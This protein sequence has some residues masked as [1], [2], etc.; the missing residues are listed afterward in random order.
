MQKILGKVKRALAVLLVAAMTVTAAPQAGLS[1]YA[2]EP[3][4]AA[5]EGSGTAKDTGKDPE[6]TRG[7]EGSENGAD[8]GESGSGGTEADV[9]EEPDGSATDGE[10]NPD[11]DVTEGKDNVL[12]EGP[13][14]GDG[15]EQ[16]APDSGEGTDGAGEPEDT[17]SGDESVSG[18]TAEEDGT[19]EAGSED[20]AVAINLEDGGESALVTVRVALPYYFDNDAKHTQISLINELW[21]AVG[22]DGELQ[23]LT[24][25]EGAFEADIP[26]E[27][28]KKLRLK[29]VL[30][31]QARLRNVW[32]AY[33]G[34][35]AESGE[36][37]AEGGEYALQI[38][39]PSNSEFEYD[40]LVRINAEH[41]YAITFTDMYAREHEGT[42]SV[43]LYRYNSEDSSEEPSDIIGETVLLTEEEISS[44]C[45]RYEYAAVAEE[46]YTVYGM[47]T[48][49]ARINIKSIVVPEN[50]K[51]RRYKLALGKMYNVP[52][53]ITVFVTAEPTQT[54]RLQF[55]LAQDIV[56][57][58]ELSVYG[59]RPGEEKNSKLE[60]SEDGC[61]DIPDDMQVS[62]DVVIKNDLEHTVHATIQENGGGEKEFLQEDVSI[63]VNGTECTRSY[64]V[65]ALKDRDVVVNISQT[66]L[67]QVNF[68]TDWDAVGNIS[69]LSP[70][71]SDYSKE[72]YGQLTDIP[73]YVPAGGKLKFTL[74]AAGNGVA[75]A[76]TTADGS[77]EIR[78]TQTDES[79]NF[80]YVVTPTGN[81][82]VY[83]GAKPYE[84]AFDY[85]KD[86]VQ[87]LVYNHETGEQLELSEDDSFQSGN[88]EMN[89][90]VLV[91]SKSEKAF[92]VYYDS[93]DG[94]Q[95]GAA[96][97]PE[98]DKDG[99]RAFII[100]GYDMKGRTILIESFTR[101]TV[102]FR[103]ND[104]GIT[105]YAYSR[106]DGWEEIFSDG[107]DTSVNVEEGE[108][109]RFRVEY[110]QFEFKLSVGMENTDSGTLEK[111]WDYDIEETAYRVAPKA[112]MTVNVGIAPRGQYTV[113]VT[114]SDNVKNYSFSADSLE[115]TGQP[116]SYY[117]REGDF[118]RIWD[119]W[120]QGDE[121]AGSLQE[122]YRGKVTY[123]SGGKTQEAPLSVY[124]G[125][126]LC[127]Q[128]AVESDVEVNIDAVQVEQRVVTFA[129]SEELESVEVWKMG[130]GSNNLYQAETG[131]AVLDDG[132]FYLF[133]FQLKDGAALQSVVM[134]NSV[135]GDETELTKRVD[136]DVPEGDG[137]KT[138]YSIGALLDDVEISVNLMSGYS[139]RFDV[140][141]AGGASIYE[142]SQMEKEITG[143][144]VVKAGN[145]SCSFY[146]EDD[147]R[148]RLTVDNEFYTLERVWSVDEEDNEGYKYV[149]APIQTADCPSS[150]TVIVERYDEHKVT[151]DYPDE[152]KSI[153]LDN[154]SGNGFRI[155]NGEAS[156]Y[157]DGIELVI[158]TIN[159]YTATVSMQGASGTETLSPFRT[160]S[161]SDEYYIGELTEDKEIHVTVKRLTQNQDD[162]YVGFLSVGGV[163]RV[164]DSVHQ[165]PYEVSR[166]S[167]D[168]GFS[169][170]VRKGESISFCVEP[171]YGYEVDRVYANKKAV[172]PVWDEKLQQD[173]YTV[174]PDEDEMQV[175]IN[176]SKTGNKY[177]VTFIYPEEM[178]SVS[179]ED[180]DLQNNVI[181]VKAGRKLYFAVDVKDGRYCVTAVL[182]N[183]KSVPFSRSKGYYVM[184][185]SAEPTEII[186]TAENKPEQEQK[187]VTFRNTAEDT[188][189]AVV[190]N[191]QVK[192]SADG[193]YLVSGTAGVLTFTVFSVNKASI[194]EVAYT[195][196][197]GTKTVL[198]AKDQTETEQGITYTYE[199][200][201]SGLSA[202]G[203]IS[204]T[205]TGTEPPVEVA[206]K[207]A[208]EACISRYK[209][210]KQEDYT[211]ETWTM[212]AQALAD[213]QT[214]LEKGN[215]TQAEVD[216]AVAALEKAAA[217]LK[218]AEEPAPVVK[219]G[220]WIE[221]I[222]DQTYTGSALKPVVRVW[223]GGTPLFDEDE[224]G[225]VAYREYSVSYKENT[226]AGEAT[227]TVKGKGNYASQ[228]TVT[229]NI[230]PKNINDEDVS[231]ADVYAMI[232]KNNT[233]NA[234]K[235]SVKWG[236]KTL[237]DGSDYKAVYP[238]DDVVNGGGHTPVA[239]RYG[240]VVKGQ[241]NYTG[242]REINYDVL[243]KDT[244]QM[245]KVKVAISVKSVAYTDGV[246]NP[247]PAVTEVSYGS[248]SKKIPLAEGTH[249]TVDYINA[250]KVGKAQVTVSAVAGSGYYGTKQVQYTVTGLPFKAARIDVQGISDTGY[251]YT[252]NE[253][254]VDTLKLYDKEKKAQEGTGQ[255]E[256]LPGRDYEAAYSKNV[257]AGKATVT[258]TGQGAY[259]GK[260]TKTFRINKFNLEDY[261]KEGSGLEWKCNGSAAYTKNGAQPEFVLTFN[262]RP[263][264]LKKDYT[265]SYSG[266][267]A[268]QP[269]QKS[270][271]VKVKGIGNFSG[272]VSETYEV[273][274]PD[275]DTIYAVAPD[276]TVPAK[277]AK[278]KTS[279]K[280]YE[281]STGKALKAGTDYDKALRYYIVEN[282]TERDVTD[283]D[284][285]V[286]RVVN[287]RITLKGNYAGPAQ[288]SSVIE[289]S[290]RLY[291]AKQK[292]SAFKVDKIADQF[293]TG[294]EIEPE[295]VVKNKDGV[296]LERDID[297]RLDYS[298]NIKKGTAKVIV[299]GIGNGY[300]GTKTVSFKIKAADVD[301]AETA[302]QKSVEILSDLVPV[303]G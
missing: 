36:L 190:I 216:M 182:A 207:T 194:L 30:K 49:T 15:K 90:R 37:S 115:E 273:T 23:Q 218:K 33:N 266:N 277:A 234:P 88:G 9:K 189:Y 196:A 148:Y 197:A 93:C 48:N 243:A 177:P 134:K 13:G 18:N 179:V 103:T 246:N 22:E 244:I 59:T 193:V 152:V 253:V 289:T 45:E 47:D 122:G 204:I 6:G 133:D 169:Y 8:S 199:A 210:Y 223:D 16:Q 274:V 157:G 31:E 98:Y 259:T 26:A 235:V 296:K 195:D 229:F 74:Y 158:R 137:N 83:L 106:Y 147:D 67:Y 21:Y 281:E 39:D 268:V 181:N 65:G 138:G 60:L 127:Y 29:P 215:V 28:G 260:I 86:D 44:F 5:D 222:P 14:K 192:E 140:S 20:E 77:N 174:V 112:N 50:R 150:V 128:F 126:S 80:Y 254:K 17:G 41:L 84:Y 35:S 300:G 164:K 209:D 303:V 203:V 292:A 66:D 89:L 123:T 129:N 286:D 291:S 261:K 271:V 7:E 185:T 135:S 249:Y 188:T 118:V 61:I 136:W 108:E 110:D 227:V 109:L 262:G 205:A 212:F 225:K 242:S 125:T 219:E 287:V 154:R 156:V 121:T 240:I 97:E 168:F 100:Y 143:Q 40:Y 283:A 226:K 241:G 270:A 217:E 1:V 120:N 3:A 151:L 251:V 54:H 107:A 117:V 279:L 231:I 298:N 70:A 91:K 299:T 282:G 76:S 170:E 302:I 24:L 186:I 68:K 248:G 239:G 73:V 230:L 116:G 278:L 175:R 139:V 69:I 255:Y 167:E 238:A 144:R 131:K 176:T 161:S 153:Y 63:Y 64:V 102:T 237:K 267:K 201:V 206:D 257:N 200:A 124:D 295:L 264:T 184:T 294:K 191:D 2:A 228:D 232:T 198:K 78:T 51:L 180:Y 256:L 114:K 52:D 233:V 130:D 171:N 224:D 55:C 178:V 34:V 293:Y 142:S 236:K 81:M 290:F 111:Y 250:D 288:G 141:K 146:L 79:G 284:M 105:L 276:V 160:Y 165:M 183:G 57:K 221:A 275:K 252:G 213:A 82:T 258:I 46:G 62:F 220:F 87:V 132:Q 38:A 187:K 297:Y 162:C 10:E 101:H 95:V 155:R 12:D 94:G 58:A 32:Y 119:I 92:A 263:L 202:T 173:V 172:A 265:V 301:F 71:E 208:L 163:V 269:G 159:G 214:C 75:Y 104:E 42:R 211:P 27:A 4:M 25:T 56:D 113:M 247:K 11:T 96:H 99:Y 245:S 149:V 272:T 53:S 19:E 280:V 285:A 43:K 166:S 145:D 72:E 85:S